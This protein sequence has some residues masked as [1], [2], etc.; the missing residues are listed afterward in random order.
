MVDPAQIIFLLA[1]QIL[2]TKSLIAIFL[3]HQL[4]IKT[5]SANV[6]RNFKDYSVRYTVPNYIRKRKMYIHILCYWAID[7]KTI[8]IK[9]FSG[10]WTNV[11]YHLAWMVV[12]AIM[13]SA[14]LNAFVLTGSKVIWKLGIYIIFFVLKTIFCYKQ[15]I[16]FRLRS[17]VWARSRWMWQSCLPKWR[18]MCWWNINLFL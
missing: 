1:H 2:K 15:V 16:L 10:M 18:N 4:T 13:K 11:Q 12:S 6:C 17:F 7:S 9:F 3:L 8:K 5:L 14:H